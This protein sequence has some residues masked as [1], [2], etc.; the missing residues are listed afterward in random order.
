MKR[1]PLLL[2]GLVVVA[3]CGG[4]GRPEQANNLILITIDTLRADFLGSY[5]YPAP[6]SPHLDDLAA[7]SIL[8]ERAYATAPFTGPS[9][10]S[11]LTGQDP[12]AHGM[13]FNG[14]RAPQLAIGRGTETLAEHLTTAGF[15][16]KAVV[17]GGPLGA[18]FG[19]GRGFESFNLVPQLDHGDSG[20]D[21]AQVHQRAT[22]WLLDWKYSGRQDRFFLWVHYFDCHL[23]F[24]SAP[25]IRDSLGIAFAG[26]VDEQNVRDLPGADVREAYRAEVFEVDAWIGRLVAELEKLELADDTIIAVV[27]DHGEYLQEHGL[28]NHHGLRDEV[29]H[30]PMFIHWRGLQATERREAVVSTIDL[31]PTLCDLLG[32]DPLPGARGRSLRRPV[33]QDDRTPVFAEWRDFRLLGDE[34]PLPGQFQISAQ[35]G[36]RK[37]IRDVIFPDSSEVFDLAV[38]PVENVNL[39][40][41]HAALADELGA[42]LDTHV[43][44]DLPAGLAG[45]QDISLDDKALEM[46]RS[47]GYVR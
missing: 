9:H 36:E 45:V 3:G 7:R 19:F 31:A 21:P 22:N 25:G 41:T 17:S 10:A 26:T 33:P 12:S 37:L 39:V 46:L 27:S 16:T 47:L 5:G 2:L 23:P 40:R 4:R 1:L 30:V 8:W 44:D 42:I 43:H 20:G 28:V 24:T 34:A 14:H 32:V 13:I 18:R 29:L 6:V 11:I 38:D 35:Q 15:N